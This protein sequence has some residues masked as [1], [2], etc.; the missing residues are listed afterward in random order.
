MPIVA[1]AARA[2]LVF[3]HSACDSRRVTGWAQVQ[4]K[5]Q[6]LYR[7]GCVTG[8]ADDRAGGG[9]TATSPEEHYAG[10]GDGGARQSNRQCGGTTSA[11][12]SRTG[13]RHVRV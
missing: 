11:T 6:S 5:H 4:D 8:P 7:V 3:K 9:G 10:G 12:G 13:R 1:S 2:M